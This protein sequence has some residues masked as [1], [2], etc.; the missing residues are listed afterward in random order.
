MVPVR[1][2]SVL[3]LALSAIQLARDLLALLREKSAR[4]ETR[5]IAIFHG[6]IQ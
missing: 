3:V 1:D 6:E 2:P 5:V 4:P